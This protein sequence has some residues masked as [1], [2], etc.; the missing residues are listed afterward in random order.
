MELLKDEADFFGAEA[1]EA[2][3]IQTRDVG[4]VDDGYASGG[5]VESAENID[6]RGLAGA[7]GAHD[8]DPLA[9]FD[10]EGDAVEGAHAAKFFAQ[11]F[12]LDERCH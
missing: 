1:R 2:G 11:I 3:F 12:D 10:G 5:R 7:R 9:L 8:G 6:Q 4:S